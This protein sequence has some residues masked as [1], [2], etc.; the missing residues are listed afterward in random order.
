MEQSEGIIIRLTKL[1]ETSL[2]VHWCTEHSGILKTVAKGARRPKSPFSGKVD[3][4]YRAEFSWVQSRKSELHTLSEIVVL[5][6]SEG[7]R[8]KYVDTLAAAYFC[9]LL[10]SVVESEHPVPE[11]YDLLQRGLNYL[12]TTGADRKSLFHYEFEMAKLLGLSS[13][14]PGAFNVLEQAYGKLPSVRANCLAMLPES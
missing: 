12:S 1:T 5:D 14:K 11:F 13:S 4:F 6:Y 3:L 10:S 7:L 8:K 2:I 9:E